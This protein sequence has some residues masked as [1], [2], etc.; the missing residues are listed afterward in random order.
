MTFRHGDRGVATSPDVDFAE[1]VRTQAQARRDQQAGEIEAEL[2]RAR[3]R[4]SLLGRLA[5][6]LGARKAVSATEG[7][8]DDR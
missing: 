8:S 3:Q 4:M 6:G 2:D 7:A 1:V 5:L